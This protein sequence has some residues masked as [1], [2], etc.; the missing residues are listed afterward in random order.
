I[1]RIGGGTSPPHAVI[2]GDAQ[3]ECDRPL[4]GRVLLDGSGSSDPESG[5]SGLTFA[6][7]EDLGLETERLLG[8]EAILDTVLPLGDHRISLRVTNA[9]GLTDTAA[10]TVAVQDTVP[11]ELTVETDPSFLKPPNHRL[12]D[13]QVGWE[14]LDVCDPSPRVT[15]ISATSSEPDAG[16]GNTTGD[17]EGADIGTADTL[18]RLRAERSGSGAGR[19]YRLIYDA[20]DR[21]G[22]VASAVAIVSVPSG[23]GN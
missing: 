20:T 22:N 11:P 9:S 3:W 21:S 17:I 19:E 23:Q 2:S 10:V 14:V 16:N 6:W 7:Y 1:M 13:V 5:Q 12:V 15:L 8:T 18:I 4:S